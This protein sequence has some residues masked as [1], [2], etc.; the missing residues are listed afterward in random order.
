M[1]LKQLKEPTKSSLNPSKVGNKKVYSK[2]EKKGEVDHKDNV[3]TT[4][5][6]ITECK[7]TPRQV[8]INKNKREKYNILEIVRYKFKW[9]SKKT[10]ELR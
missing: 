9:L 7:R 1:N 5:W 8:K 6:I 4:T 2:K 3:Y 10:V